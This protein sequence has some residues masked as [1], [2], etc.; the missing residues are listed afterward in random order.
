MKKIYILSAMLFAG[1]AAHSQCS[2]VVNSFTNVTCNGACDGSANLTSLG[3]PPYT[4]S[5]APGG[6]TVQNP[7][8]LCPGTHTVT[9]VDANSCQSTATV[10]ITEPAVLTTSTSETDA[11]C[12]G[13]CNGTATATPAGGTQP[14]TY[15][16]DS[17]AANQVTATATGLCAGTYSVLITDANGCTTS[18][19]VT[20][21]EPNAL[22]VNT[23][24]LPTSCQSCTDGSAT[25]V[26]T[27]GTPSYTYSWQP[28][29]QTTS[30]ASNLSAGSYTVTITDAQGCTVMDTILVNSPTGVIAYD[31]EFGV[32]VYPNPIVDKANI[33]IHNGPADGILYITVFDVTGKLI[34]SKQDNVTKDDVT[35]VSF[36][37]LPPG[38]YLMEIRMGDSKITVKVFRQ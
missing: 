28:G 7:I 19:Q 22:M 30:T 38:A 24:S 8:D 6:Q 4:Y 27:G 18:D 26:V 21:N 10:T 35:Q 16:W 31:G 33:E 9:M 25:A 2:V 32:S 23:S 37:N 15:Q 36:V 14:Y 20:V 17:T 34:E 12:N 5:W 3:L 13:S 11:T 29:G 1:I